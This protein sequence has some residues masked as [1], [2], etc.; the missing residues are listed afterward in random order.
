MSLT[1]EMGRDRLAPTLV[2]YLLVLILL[3]IINSKPNY[4]DLIVLSLLFFSLIVIK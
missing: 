1:H 4:P 2:H 3:M